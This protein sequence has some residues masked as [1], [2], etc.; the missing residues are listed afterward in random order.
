MTS[1]RMMELVTGLERVDISPGEIIRLTAAF[2]QTL[3]GGEAEESQSLRDNLTRRLGEVRV[4]RESGGPI[5]LAALVAEIIEIGEPD[6]FSS[7]SPENYFQTSPFRELGELPVTGNPAETGSPGVTRVRELAHIMRTEVVSELP[8]HPTG[9]DHDGNTFWLSKKNGF[10]SPII[11][12]FLQYWASSEVRADGLDGAPYAG[13][14]FAVASYLCKFLSS[15]PEPYKSA[16]D[17]WCAVARAAPKSPFPCYELTALVRSGSQPNFTCG[18]SSKTL[19]GVSYVK[20]TL[21]TSLSLCPLGVSSE[22]SG[23]LKKGWG[24]FHKF[25]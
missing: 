20:D 21:T 12:P 8:L 2:E 5:T 1:R 11:I 9:A 24:N 18:E 15:S 22:H 4:M 13:G 10:W 7:L 16:G 23:W 19:H 6:A 17:W 3:G 25:L 14:Y